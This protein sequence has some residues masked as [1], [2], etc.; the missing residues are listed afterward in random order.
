MEGLTAITERKSSLADIALARYGN[1]GAAE[2]GRML[3]PG[4]GPAV[5]IGAGVWYSLEA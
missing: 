3:T 2:G 4:R 5:H 1:K